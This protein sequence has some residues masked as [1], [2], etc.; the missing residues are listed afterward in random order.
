MKGRHF[1]HLLRDTSEEEIA[2]HIIYWNYLAS[3]GTPGFWK[4]WCLVIKNYYPFPQQTGKSAEEIAQGLFELSVNSLKGVKSINS[5][6]AGQETP[7][8]G[9]VK[10]IEL[11]WAVIELGRR[12]YKDELMSSEQIMSS[13]KLAHKF[14]RKSGYKKQ[15]HLAA[16]LFEYAEEIIYQQTIFIGTVNRSIASHEIPRIM[17]WS[18]WQPPSFWL[19][20]IHLCRVSSKMMMK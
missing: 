12:I 3:L 19:I 10:A 9:R 5:W 8:I 14:N 18:T 1:L 17:H 11:L 2:W 16:P 6:G 13:Q 4:E 20:I 15:E 7:G